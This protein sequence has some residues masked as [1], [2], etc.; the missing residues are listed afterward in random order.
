MIPF[1]PP[2]FT[3]Q[4]ML[5][6]VALKSIVAHV[7]EIGERMNVEIVKN[8]ELAH[9]WKERFFNDHCTVMFIPLP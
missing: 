9:S 8:T 2:E 5:T 1:V 6:D 4:A 7:T 3:A